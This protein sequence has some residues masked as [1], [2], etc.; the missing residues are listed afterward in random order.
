MAALLL[1]MNVLQRWLVETLKLRLRD[2]LV[3]DLLGHWMLPRRAFWLANAGAIG[4]NPDQRM[5]EDARKLCDL[6]A[7]L[8]A[9]LLQA[10]ILFLTFASVLWGLSTD[11]TVRFA[12]V[13]YLVPGFM[14]WAAI[15][16]A[17]IG[18][19]MS[20]WVGGSLVDRNAE[21]YAREA[22]LRFSM[23]RINEHLDGISLAGG[24]ADE[25]RRV[26]MHLGNVL[27]ATARLIAGL[28]NLTWITA[29]FGWIT[30]V[31]PILV[32]APLYFGGKIS[33]GG[34]MMAAA[35][36][37]QAQGSLRWFVDNFSVIADWRATLLRVAS[38]RLALT[39]PE[40]EKRF[41]GHI[42]YAEAAG[43]SLDIEQLQIASAAGR[44]MLKE[45]DVHVAPG[46]RVLILGA[47]GTEKTLLFRALA[48]LWP[49][50][51]GRV[52]RPSGE[53]VFY[54]PRGTPYLPRGS[55]REVLAY[56]AKVEQ[57]AADRYAHALQRLGLTRLVAALDETQRWDLTLSFDE[58][59]TLAFT[60]IVLQRPR[61]VLIDGTLGALEDEALESV[62]DVLEHEL[63]ES[64]VIHI[65]RASLTR[66]AA[67]TRVLHLVKA[68]D[69]SQSGQYPRPTP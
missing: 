39:S 4:V 50:G 14:L 12:G 25:Q 47:P 3:H 18:S 35:A 41:G 61:W 37:T 53:A 44:D 55:L 57:F 56:P 13:D 45:S 52:V 21:R 60:R 59:L 36:F 62:L 38:F 28:T 64:A 7:D 30:T 9:G 17:A 20:Y 26:D 22:D 27:A 40:L 63:A 19:L 24:E 67:Q 51:G 68:S 58:Q 65:G 31:A 54:L 16:Y 33:F 1:A 15:V 32:A 66:D 43:H 69:A 34:L 5:H 11:F 10:T 6:T 29:G 49:W 2:G 42:E 23:V 48:G 46:E 8:G